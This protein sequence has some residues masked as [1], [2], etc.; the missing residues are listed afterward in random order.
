MNI[1]LPVHHFPPR[2]NA[3]AEL[4]TFRLARWLQAH[5][6]EAEVVCI[7][8]IERGATD[9]LAVVQD[10]YEGISVHRLSFNLLEAP[11]RRQWDYDCPLLGEWFADHLQRSRPNLVH[12]QAGYL[13]GAAPIVAAHAAGIPSAL[14]L[15]DYWFLCP[16][17]TLQRGDGAVC[18]SIPA[19]PVGCAW[20]MK[21]EQRRFQLADRATAG[22]FGR[23]MQMIGLQSER[24][25]V[26]ARRERLFT[27]LPLLDA[28]IAPS[29]FMADQVAPYVVPAR[30]EVSRLGLDLGRF[31][32][33]PER[34]D[35]TLRIGFLGQVAPHKGVHL[36]IEAATMLQPRRPFE[37]HIHGGLEARP[38]Y[39]AQLR[40]LAGD[41]PHITFHGRFENS[42]AGEILAGLDLVV[43]PSTWYENSPLSILEAH[44]AGT[45]VVTA[46]MGGMAELVH[47]GVDGMHFRPGD[48]ADLARRLQRA[49]DDPALIERLRAGITPPRSIDDEMEHLLGIYSRLAPHAMRT[50]E[51]LH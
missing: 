24:D 26:A 4:Y 1:L 23:G 48:A 20:C 34:R 38:D 16:R 8:S 25:W 12:F 47:D 29:Q 6:H 32:V 51:E 19:D 49:I 17:I 7:E 43:V 13:L 5:G 21:L 11:E 3:G 35:T 33:R 14:T 22:L 2:Y 41:R 46:A 9:R 42:R 50:A 27:T 30:L 40:T 15:H 36:L 28:V 39:V 45:P 37:I 10:S 18:H 44:A 31:A